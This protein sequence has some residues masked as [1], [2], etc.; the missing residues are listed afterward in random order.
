MI[1]GTRG[2]LLAALRGLAELDVLPDEQRRVAAEAAAKL[3]GEVVYVAVLGEF[4]RG[5]SS[6]INAL[7]G[8]PVLPTGVTPVTAAPALVRFGETKRA[9]V[10]MQEG[11]DVPIPIDALAEYMTEQGN[12]GNRRGVREVLIAHPSALLS[13]GLVLADTPGTGSVHAHNTEM[14]AAFLPRVD[15]ALLVLTVD[16]PLSGAEADLLTAVGGSVARAAICL[17]KVDLLSEAE[18]AEAVE[19]V[20]DRVARLTDGGAVPV[21]PVSARRA[22][23]GEEGG[24]PAVRHFLADIA[25]GEREAVLGAR[26][27][28]VAEGLLSVASS[29]IALERAALARP[30]E[31]ARAARATFE[32]ARRELEED[33]AEA[34]TLLLAACRR[35]LPEVIEPHADR[36]RREL[37]AT[38]LAQPDGEW[39][40][41]SQRAASAWT[42]IVEAE[43]SAVVEAAL[44]RHAERLQE[45]VVR[46]V[47][48]A[49][50]AFDVDLPPPPDV[51][52][53]LRIPDIRIEYAEEPGALAM[54]VLQMR[55]HLPGA[56]GD[57]W[58]E[59]AR[60]V[61]AAREADRLAGRL[62]YG[63]GQAVDQ[64]ARSWARDV[65]RGWRSL[66]DSLAAAVARAEGAAQ[67]GAEDAA[68][69][70][71]AGR[72]EALRSRLLEG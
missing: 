29:A 14:T 10:R 57:R 36:L 38:L 51:R 3:A 6:L 62:R 56:L 24:L 63:A 58:R 39:R 2:G 70:D 71:M 5:K 25:E 50:E 16:A 49:G 31:Q 33:A 34:V 8:D 22:A 52:R 44:K 17:N 41:P 67:G 43:L 27:R 64:A 23:A 59:R 48:R 1:T 61:E 19:F 37:P 9:T 55:R 13:P 11:A 18:L 40:E 66:S 47:R 15:V 35:T 42:A 12:P 30:A 28:T 20:R 72:L 65:E 68:L 46:F 21:F 69:R 7:L 32:E 45:R 26:A 54:G 53:E 60:Q 4:K